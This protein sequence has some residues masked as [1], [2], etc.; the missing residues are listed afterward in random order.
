MYRNYTIE[1]RN[2]T[3]NYSDG[4]NFEQNIVRFLLENEHTKAYFQNTSGTE[5]DKKQGTDF[6]F[7]GMPVDT[8]LH[9]D[10]KDHSTI[11]SG[12]EV[13]LSEECTVFF[14]I[15]TGNKHCTF[16]KP[17]LLMGFRS[18]EHAEYQRIGA[19]CLRAIERNIQQLLCYGL[20]LYQKYSPRFASL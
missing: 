7:G 18:M 17:V 5:L 10:G 12:K 14:G 13:Q 3:Q 16:D 19:R 6:K 20:G 8:T 1:K 4:Y 15:R 9:M 11:L 2:Y